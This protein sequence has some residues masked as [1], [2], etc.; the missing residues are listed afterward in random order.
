VQLHPVSLSLGR[1]ISLDP[2]IG[3]GIGYEVAQERY[4]AEAYCPP[5]HSG[6]C[7]VPHTGALQGFEWFNGQ[8]G[9]AIAFDRFSVGPY[10]A[11]S[12]GVYKSDAGQSLTEGVPHWWLNAGLRFTATP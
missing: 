6:Y 8:V 7:D 11:A 1:G 9:L 10:F 5:M 2:W 4:D 12:Y 3:L